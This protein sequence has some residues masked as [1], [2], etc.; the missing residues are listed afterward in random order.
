MEQAGEQQSDTRAGRNHPPARG[1]RP[2]AEYSRLQSVAA[3]WS[4][5]HLST[6]GRLDDPASEH[7]RRQ[8]TGCMET[9]HRLLSDCDE[10]RDAVATCKAGPLRHC[11]GTWIL[12][13]ELPRLHIGLLTLERDDPVPV[14]DHSRTSGAQLLLAGRLA[15]RQFQRERPAGAAPDMFLLTPV[16]RW[17]LDPGDALFFT[18][19]ADV[20]EMHALSER[21]VTLHVQLD[22]ERSAKRGWYFPH[23]GDIGGVCLATRWEL[24]A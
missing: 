14:H 6:L 8:A 18:S 3:S 20:H 12:L 17:T 13:V 19:S 24:D 21:S 2:R 4:G 22:P 11:G 5:E 1:E 15:I 10:Y 9:L 16:G 23:L 7:Q